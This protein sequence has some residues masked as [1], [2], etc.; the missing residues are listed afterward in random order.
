MDDLANKIPKILEKSNPDKKR[1]EIK[2]L[3][4]EATQAE[5]WQDNQAAAA[6]MRRLTTLQ[7]E[8]KKLAKLENWLLEQEMGTIGNS[9]GSPSSPEIEKTIAELESQLYLSGH[10][11]SSSAIINIHSGQGGVEA[12]D[13]AEML[14]RMYTQYIN[15]R[16]WKLEEVNY[17][18][19]GEAGIKTVTFDVT[20][21]FA[22]G[23]LKHE[24]GVHRLVRLS[25]FNADHLRQTSFAL[26][27]VLPAV[28]DD[29][30]EV[31]VLD[32]DIDWDFFR[33]GGHGGQNV[34]KVSSAVRLT[35]RPSGIII[36]SQKERDQSRNR[37]IALR[38]LKAKLLAIQEEKKREEEMRLKGQHLTPGWGNQIRSYVLHPYHLVKDL[39]TDYEETDSQA[40]L[41]GHLDG[42]IQAEVHFFSHT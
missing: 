27:E 39:R 28:S 10:Y 25:P 14:Y 20:G 4:A 5:F 22:Y 31:K 26:V 36:T 3:E 13:W 8:V 9:S 11:D 41:N 6:K 40:V 16:G 35:H 1:Q 34:N 29:T 32:E 12:M 38:I 17:E 19:G 18:P 37:E 23:L 42:F 21:P 24:A 33:S 7:D 15:S 30:S 2:K